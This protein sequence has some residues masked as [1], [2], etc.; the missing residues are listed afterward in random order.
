MKDQEQKNI[1]L[2]MNAET[3]LI[4]HFEMEF[5][6][7]GHGEFMNYIINAMIEHAQYNVE[8]A[9][10]LIA[11]KYDWISIE[12]E[13]PYCWERG[14]WDGKRSDYVLVKSK[15]ETIHFA[16]LYSGTLDGNEFNDFYDRNDFEIEAVSWM[17]IHD[18]QSILSTAKEYVELNI[19]R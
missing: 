7:Q 1:D 13:L 3:I 9:S 17:N 10:E 16:I 12:K 14:E 8:K 11:E 5:K 19:K 4:K 2:P 6:H 15:D 18:K